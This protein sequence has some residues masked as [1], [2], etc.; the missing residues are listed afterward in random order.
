MRERLKHLSRDDLIEVILCYDHHM[1]EI[2]SQGRAFEFVL[3]ALVP[4]NCPTGN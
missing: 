1:G 2:L 4:E 3:E